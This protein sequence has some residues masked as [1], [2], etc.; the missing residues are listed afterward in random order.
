MD[1]LGMLVQA[2]VEY[3]QQLVTSGGIK[4]AVSLLG[5]HP[6]VVGVQRAGSMLLGVLSQKSE[7]AAQIVREGGAAAVARA[8]QTFSKSS[9]D[10]L[11]AAAFTL[12]NLEHHMKIKKA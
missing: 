6:N 5:M 2:Q 9:D 1:I 12:R 7:F 4:L 3:A 10:L 8:M 11:G